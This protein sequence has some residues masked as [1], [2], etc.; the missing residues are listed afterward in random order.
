MLDSAL[1]WNAW[2]FKKTKKKKEE[3]S[4]GGEVVIM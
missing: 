4:L 2:C 3:A 1:K